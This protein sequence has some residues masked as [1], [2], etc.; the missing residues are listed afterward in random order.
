MSQADFSCGANIPLLKCEFIK[1]D[2]TSK[3][4]FDDFYAFGWDRVNIYLGP[5]SVTDKFHIIIPDIFKIDGLLTK[6]ATT[7]Y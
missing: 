7:Q 5:E 1:G 4:Y 2:R 6:D 3:T